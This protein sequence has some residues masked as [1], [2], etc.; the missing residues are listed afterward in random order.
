MKK[1]YKND[2]KYDLQ[3]EDFSKELLDFLDYPEGIRLGDELE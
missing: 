2:T 1:A 3:A